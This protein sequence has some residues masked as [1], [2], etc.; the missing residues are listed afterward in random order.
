MRRSFSGHIVGFGTTSGTRIVIGAWNRSPF[1][2]FADAMIEQP[3]GHRI[4]IAPR[5]EIAQFVAATYSFDEV[6]IEPIS[7]RADD[8]WSI[9]TRT[10]QA[11]VTP[12]RRLWVS[13]PLS[14][15]PAVVRRTPRWAK[16]CNPIAGRLMPGVQTYGSAG[17]GRQ[18]WYAA[19]EV[20][21][22]THISATWEGDEL[23]DL[24]AV[25]P[26]VHFGFASPP[27][28]PT[29]TTLTSYVQDA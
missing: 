29:L 18:E 16:V 25:T 11:R 24:A 7:V 26:P 10:M 27:T 23:G 19:T 28:T 15:V 17:G 6:R 8:E 21:R 14:L 13:V 20:R 22:L 5:A 2:A 12:G 3:N 9:H 1:G 4:L